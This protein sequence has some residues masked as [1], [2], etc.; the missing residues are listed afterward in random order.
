MKY[1]YKLP[2]RLYELRKKNNLSQQQVADII[3]KS[4]KSYQ[5][6]ER[7]ESDP[8]FDTVIQLA[9]YYG[10]SLNYMAGFTDDPTPV[11]QY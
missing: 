9:D 7:G 8:L 2:E 4:L 6:Y 11:R 3:D 10:V 1:V 5:R